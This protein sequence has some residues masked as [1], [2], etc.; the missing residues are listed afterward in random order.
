MFCIA[1]GCHGPEF[2]AEAVREW[3]AAVGARTAYI[4]PG[5][6]WEN[7]DERELQC[8][9]QARFTDELLNG[10]RRRSPDTASDQE[11]VARRCSIKPKTTMKTARATPA[12]LTGRDGQMK[13]TPVTA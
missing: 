11:A 3:I 1:T 5:S 8:P 2:V 10:G 4:E 7:G 12:P 6:P 13:E 9:L